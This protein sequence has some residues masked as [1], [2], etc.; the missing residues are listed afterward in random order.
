[1]KVATGE[2]EFERDAPRPE[3]KPDQA[4]P[5]LSDANFRMAA[6]IAA[7]VAAFCA[8]VSLYFLGSPVVA[9]LKQMPV[10]VWA[11]IAAAVFA[12]LAWLIVKKLSGR[13]G[14]TK[15]G[16][17]RWARLTAYVGFA[18]LALFG[19]VALHQLPEF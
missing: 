14:Y 16:Q 6:H 9:G 3:P 19:A 18:V 17:G 7:I 2:E 13:L 4:A 12:G 5:A 11:G 15:A 10:N 8:S 1:M